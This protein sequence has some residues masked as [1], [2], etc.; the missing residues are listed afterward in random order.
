MPGADGDRAKERPTSPYR[1][2]SDAVRSPKA[3]QTVAG[4]THPRPQGDIVRASE[5][6]TMADCGM[7]RDS[8]QVALAAKNK[9]T[10]ATEP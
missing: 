9:G 4:A 1:V 6:S 3:S 8:A 5:F 7:N 10:S 2:R